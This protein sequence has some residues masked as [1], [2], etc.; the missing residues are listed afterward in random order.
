MFYDLKI[1]RESYELTQREIA[2]ILK[3]SKSSYNYFE[4]GEH[5]IPLKHLNNFCNTFHVSMDFVCNL[6][7]TNIVDNKKY[8]LKSNEIGRRLKML[9]LKNKLTQKEL[10]NILN[11]TQ[12][13]ISSYENGN[14]LILTAFLYNYAKYFNVSLDYLAGRSNT[15]NIKTLKT[16]I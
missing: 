2:K 12:S 15:I 10:A 7:K 3:I 11:T 14:T 5:I 16:K 9:R 6:T 1:I 4:T 8:K 13:N